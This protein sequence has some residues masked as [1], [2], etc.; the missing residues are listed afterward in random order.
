M[1]IVFMGT[2]DFA[3]PSLKNLICK[4]HEIAG[5]VTQP[6]RPKGRG[7]KLSFSA[8]KQAALEAGLD[9]FQPDKIKTTE[10]VETLKGLAPEMI[11]VAAFG[12][13]LSKEILT[14]PKFGCVNVH[15]SLLPRYRGAAPI[16]WAVINGE[17]ET[18]VTIIQ[19]DSGLDTGDM[20]LTGKIPVMPDD[21][22]GKVHD[23]LADLGAE[24]LV[25]A[26]TAISY[27]KIERISQDN[28]RASY[29][30][31]LTNE[32]EKIDWSKSPV[33]ISKLVRGLNPWPVA[34]TVFGEKILKIWQA[35]PCDIT[36]IQGPLIDLTQKHPGQVLGRI[37]GVGFAVAAGA[38]C[39]AVCEVQPQGSRRMNAEDF[40]N[41]HKL[42]KGT[43]LG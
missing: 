33:K 35:R 39:M 13:L 23:K 7:Q 21:N 29:A 22:T 26:I 41:G 43:V 12:Q 31:I 20:L 19:M 11:V 27:G 38:G 5:V 14:L 3:V 34:H 10:F 25:E 37:P 30:P 36:E 16:H 17:T 9:I 2:P 32:I 24:L 4:G 6:D 8:V 15:A 18:G 42:T 1:R 28:S 40:M